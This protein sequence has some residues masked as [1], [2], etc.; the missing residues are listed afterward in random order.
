MS[1]SPSS[2]STI[3]FV[4]AGGWAN[5]I[6]WTTCTV[7]CG[8]GSQVRTRLCNNP[9]PIYGGANCVG[10]GAETQTCNTQACSGPVGMLLWIFKCYLF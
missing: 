7:T 3:L 4:K 9:A 8:G 2:Y 10:A 5:W 1:I 6:A